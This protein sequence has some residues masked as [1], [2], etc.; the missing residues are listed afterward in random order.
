[1]KLNV[2]VAGPQGFRKTTWANCSLPSPLH[3]LQRKFLSCTK[4]W[5][6]GFGTRLRPVKS[7]SQ[8][9]TPTGRWLVE[10]LPLVPGVI[11][12]AH[13]A[14]DYGR[15]FEYHRRCSRDCA[16]QWR[17]ACLSGAKRVLRARF[18]A[19]FQLIATTNL[20]PCANSIPRKSMDARGV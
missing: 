13:V 6:R 11:S 4:C 18:P 15:I 19:D 7:P 10:G 2:L 3:R 12:R 16:S 20:C 5:R 17:V 14:F 9:V 1:M 8:P